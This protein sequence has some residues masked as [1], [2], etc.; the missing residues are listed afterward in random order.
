M[1]Q[2]KGTI[3]GI[4]L[5][6]E[7]NNEPLS[8]ASVVIKDTAI[9]TETDLDGSFSLSVD[10]GSYI[11]VFNF[12]GY[13]TLEVPVIVVAG[14]T[15][16]VNSAL[17]AAEGV[18][19]EEVKLK[20]STSKQK[21]SALLLEQ[22]KAT[23][24][25]E[26]IGAERLNKIGVS[27]AASATTKISGVTRSEES[28]DIYIRGLGDRYLSTSMNGLPIPSDD[29]QNKNIDLSLFS[30]N[31]IN[32][33]G[34]SKTYT[35][36]SY[37]DQSSG[38]VDVISKKYSKKGVTI[39]INAGLNSAVTNLKGGFKKTVISDDVTFGFHN[40]KYILSDAI[41]YQGWDPLAANN[42]TNFNGSLSAAYKFKIFD[43]DFSILA[44][45][46]HGQ[47]FEYQEGIFKSYRANILDNDFTTESF[48]TNTNTTG[49]IRG[50]LKLNDKHKISYNTLFVNKGVDNVYEQGRYGNGY[51]FDQQPQEN[52]AIVRDQ[53]YKQT[54]MF[55]NQLMGTHNLSEKNSL[56]WAVGYNFVLAEEP[57]RIRN[58]G[59][60]IDDNGTFTYAY[61]GDFQQ[62]KT[63]QKI[64]DDEI[65]GYI[66]DAF[67]FGKIDED[68]KRP[69]RL[70]IGANFRYK[71]RSFKSLF[72]G[73]SARDFSVVSIDAISN[74]FTFN[75]FNTASGQPELILREQLP[76]VYNADLTVL[77]GYASLD[78]GLNKKFSGNIGVRYELDKINIIWDVANFVGRIGTTTKD[79]N[80]LY[81]SLNLKYQLNEKSFLRFAS[82]ITQ[83]LPEFKE[84]APFEYV[85]PTGRVIKG[86][87]NLEKS[88]VFNMDA[89][90]EFFPSSEELFSTTVFFK[91]IQDPIN[92][93]QARGSAGIFQYENTG[94]TASVFGIE[95]EGRINII[96][97]D[98][99]KSI[100]SAN[101]NLTQMW[102]NQD[103]LELFQY[104]NI[105]NTNL[106]GASDFIANGSISYNSRATKEFIASI[107]GNYSSD[108]IYALGS[109]ED[110]VNSATLF[111]DEIIE[112]G[113]VS[114]DLVISKKLND[115]FLLRFTGKN[116]LNP[117]I[118]QTQLV[119][120]FDAN[121]NIV[122]VSNQKVQSYKKGSLFSLGLSY[123]F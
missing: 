19:L 102:F 55:V 120:V 21:E 107:T 3:T 116:L 39:G 110:F 103:I 64:Q 69:F 79:Y 115:K 16:R 118:D 17:E 42:T 61:V 97:N 57:N 95:L 68:E 82:S 49:Y 108:K 58:E 24:I 54:T 60:V 34:I 11:L 101:A 35:T 40:K 9:G 14:E 80:E 123:K 52:G 18:S 99:E 76:D 45:A 94:E 63:S 50:D 111:N 77:A 25:K 32:S 12:L 113:F 30:N 117:N 122:E 8:F 26:S 92:L 1:A 85:S 20:A 100:L 65:N 91:N 87:P 106:Q 109:P 81:P 43:K 70:N 2:V 90:W 121:D 88:S 86:N 38:N 6:K 48:T 96:E 56:R 27:N 37:A 33:I 71:E 84:V 104:N 31:L 114:L 51:V 67:S 59:N 98:D 78:F 46:S 75:N 74:T 28:G 112:K 105:T 15:V 4:L 62:R 73:V 72:V 10:S 22:R 13:K 7:M 66:E 23:T 5:D 29:V 53:N 36:S 93:T 44:T 47:S 89:K 83:T 41:T 119:T